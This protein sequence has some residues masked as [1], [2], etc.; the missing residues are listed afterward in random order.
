MLGD[1]LQRQLV[2]HDVVVVGQEVLLHQ[3][4]DVALLVLYHGGVG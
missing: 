1:L 3:E 4:E 2:E